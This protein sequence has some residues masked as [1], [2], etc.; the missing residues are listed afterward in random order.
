MASPAEIA[1]IDASGTKEW[2]RK[3]RKE[4]K[5][6]ANILETG[7]MDLARVLYDVWNTPIDNDPNNPPIFTFWGHDSFAEYAENELGLHQRKAERLRQ[8]WGVIHAELDLPEIA[9]ERLRRIGWS[10]VRELCQVFTKT[11]YEKWLDK[12][13]HVSYP[14]LVRLV[15][16]AK[17]RKA[18]KER[19]PVVKQIEKQD[20]SDLGNDDHPTVLE[21]ADEDSHLSEADIDDLRPQ[22][23]PSIDKLKVRTFQLYPDQLDVVDQAL[24]RASELSNSRKPGHNLTMICTEFLAVNNFGKANQ[25]NLLRHVARLEKALGIRLA[26]FDKESY[27]LLYGIGTIERFTKGGK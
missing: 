24:E 13:E 15:E 8:I 5:E 11:N 21:D 3:I 16:D 17:K 7:Y 25:E 2:A 27:E 12:A 23:S 20:A 19:A 10:K 26:A 18:A 14:I 22:E 4:A 1:P 6:L 9:R